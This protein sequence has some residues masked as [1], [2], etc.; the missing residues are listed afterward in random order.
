MVVFVPNISVANIDVETIK[1]LAIL[2]KPIGFAH[3]YAL[4]MAP[5]CVKTHAYLNFPV[6]HRWS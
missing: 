3:L 6:R 4:F 2:T 5:F 1:V